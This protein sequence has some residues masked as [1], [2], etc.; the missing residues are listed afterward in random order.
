MAKLSKKSRL[1]LLEE[2]FKFSEGSRLIETGEKS[3]GTYEQNCLEIKNY[4][5]AAAVIANKLSESG[6]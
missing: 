4:K 5:R 3:V 2:Y 1:F 6:S